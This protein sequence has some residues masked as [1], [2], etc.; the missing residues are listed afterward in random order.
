MMI[1]I[2]LNIITNTRLRLLLKSGTI[3][4]KIHNQFTT[5]NLVFSSEKIQS[6]TR[7]FEVQI[8]LH[9]RSDH[10]SI[11]TELNLQTISVQSSTCRL[12]KK[13]NTEALS[14]YLQIHFSS[15]HS[16]N[17]R[18]EMNDRVTKIIRVLQEIIEKST[19]WAK[20]SNWVRDFWNQSCFEVVTKSRWLQTVWKMQDTLKT[21]NKYLK[22]NDH[23][24]K[25]IKQTKCAHFRSQMHEL[26]DALK[27]IWRF[28]KWARIESQLF[29]T[30]SQFLSLKQDDTDHMTTTFEK[31]FKMLRGK[32]FSLFS[33]ADISNISDSFISLTISSNSR[34]SKNEMKRVIRQIKVNKASDISEISNRALQANFTELISVL[35][36]LFN[37]CMIHKYHSKQFKKPQTIVLCKSKK[38]DYIDLK[39]YWLIVLLDIMSKALES[40]LIKRLSDITE[41]HHMLL[42]AQTRAR[43]KWFVI[44]TLNLLVNQVH[45]MWDCKIKYVIFM[46]NLNVVKAFDW[47]LHIRLLHTL[48]MRR[49]SSYIVEWACS[50]LKNRETSLIFN[51]QM[52]TMREINA[53]ISQ[54]SLISLIFFLFFNASLIEKCKELKIKIEV[55]NFVNDINILV[56]DRFIE[57]ICK[58]LSKTHDVCAKWAWTHD[59]TFA[60]EKYELT[61]F[62]RK[63][64]KFNMMTSI[65]I[66]S[67][68]IKSKSDVQVLKTQLNMKLQWDAHLWQIEV[69]HVTRMLT[70]SRLKVFIW[71]TIFTKMRQVYSAVIRSEIAFEASVWHQRNKE[72][73]LSDKKCKLETL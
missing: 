46:L 23:K 59:T 9:Q 37:V 41:T 15:D 30:L 54:E 26:S 14:A 50:F 25:I 31:K 72:K 49:T 1:N 40:I 52:S 36:S 71:E 48:K 27:S 6:I 22:H 42:N 67:S 53:D 58:T 11:V 4:C 7:K 45:I 12:W 20:S 32:F 60:S 47:V 19:F 18:A 39:T 35:M 43:R 24:N 3:T 69:S 65:Q 16:L 73:E 63:S 34:I 13:M 2:L 5:I 38:S 57:E 10:L 51:E 21:W 62:I 33:Q 64:R 70:L 28:A 17:S 55:F 44:L 68:V 56:Y 61:H 8:N 29:K 66:K